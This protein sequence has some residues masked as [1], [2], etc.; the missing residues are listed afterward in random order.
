MGNV[1]LQ[2]KKWG[3]FFKMKNDGCSS[4]AMEQ[5]G[6]VTWWNYKFPGILLFHIPNGGARH[7]ITAHNLKKVG[8]IRGIPD[9]YC[10]KFHLWIEFKRIKGG[11]L[12]PDQEKIIDY[13]RRIGDTVIIAYGSE[14]GSRQFLTFLKERECQK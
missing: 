13:L 2:K 6:F 8:V 12:S 9:L 10:P 1:I 3:T 11:K 7:I 4:E 14:D 5:E